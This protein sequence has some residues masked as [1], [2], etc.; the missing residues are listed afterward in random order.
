[1]SNKAIGMPDSDETARPR[2]EHIDR[3][4]VMDDAGDLQGRQ[5]SNKSG[6][7]S[8]VEKLAASRPEFNASPGA[9]RVPGAF[10]GA[11]REEAGLGG[12][13]MASPG[14]NQF[15]C[16][17]CGRHFNTQSEL[18]EHEIECR[19]AKDAGRHH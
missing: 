16:D 8:S 10:G 17:T 9:H 18:S 13:R 6:K 14:T 3:E 19:L 4:E 15:R 5:S 1:M 2:H 12:P 11:T 7:H